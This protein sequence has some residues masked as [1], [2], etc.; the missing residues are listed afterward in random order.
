M[1]EVL[2]KS[3]DFLYYQWILKARLNFGMYLDEQKIGRIKCGQTKEFEIEYG[4]H[5]VKAKSGLFRTGKS[6]T[7][8]KTHENKNI[9]LSGFDY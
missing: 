1:Y 8:L 7:N 4:E 9:E 2:D 3:V 5:Q 6:P